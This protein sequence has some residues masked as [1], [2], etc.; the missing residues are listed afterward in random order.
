MNPFL[1]A[2]PLALATLLVWS[3][4]AAA[5]TIF[6]ATGNDAGDI[7]AS[8]NVFRTALGNPNNANTPGPLAGGRREINWDGGGSSATSPGGTPF[9]VFLNR[10]IQLTTPGTGFFQAPASGLASAAAFNNPTYATIFDTFSPVRLFV[11]VGSNITEG[12][13]SIPGSNGVTP[14]GVRGFGAVFTDVDLTGSTRIEL[15]DFH[16]DAFFSADVTPLPGDATL[17]FLGLLT[18]AGEPQ[19]AGVRITSGNSALGPNDGAGIDVVAMDDFLFS[20][21]RLIPQPAA[22]VLLSIGMIFAGAAAAG[23]VRRR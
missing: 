20:E 22:A 7:L 23:R 3:S 8:V 5:V 19:I 21:P 10:G 14:A 18:A 6:S 1:R 11:P 2:L 17:S 12:H 13:F 9:N 4:G 16:G 15:L